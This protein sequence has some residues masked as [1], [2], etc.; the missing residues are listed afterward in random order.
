MLRKT[1]GAFLALGVSC[2]ASVA[3]AVPIFDG[4]VTYIAGNTCGVAGAS[5]S[6]IYRPQIGAAADE[7]TLILFLYR[8]GVG[9]SRPTDGQFDG[10]GSFAMFFVTPSATLVNRVGS[11]QATQIPASIVAGTQTINITATFDPT[12]GCTFKFKGVFVRRAG[13]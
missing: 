11:F 2:A 9:F 4:T 13:T 6:A 5:Y 3:T 7:S 10:A 1:L 12:A 8:S